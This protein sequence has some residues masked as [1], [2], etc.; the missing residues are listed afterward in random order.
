MDS[1]N[2]PPIPQNL[3][4]ETLCAIFTALERL[5][6]E[7]SQLVCKKWDSIIQ[8]HENI[9]PLRIISKIYIVSI[10]DPPSF[11]VILEYG[12]D[13]VESKTVLI[14]DK[15]MSASGFYDLGVDVWYKQE[16]IEK[17]LGDCVFRRCQ[18]PELD[19]GV[20]QILQVTFE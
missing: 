11:K 3:P 6:I 8:S 9:L 7:K 14:A 17:W 18:L 16:N 10:A 19:S 20:V 2:F 4:V 1:P 5:E 15:V 12:E 13:S